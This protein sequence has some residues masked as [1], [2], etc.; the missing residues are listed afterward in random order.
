MF[1]SSNKKGLYSPV[2]IS[3]GYFLHTPF[4]VSHVNTEF[5]DPGLLLPL[6]GYLFDQESHKIN[7]KA[8]DRGIE[9]LFPP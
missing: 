2:F 5:Y 4:L 1:F 3:G 9:P 6:A 8:A 7:E